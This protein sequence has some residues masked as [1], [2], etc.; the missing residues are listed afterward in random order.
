MR[1][2]PSTGSSF[3]PYISGPAPLGSCR[4]RSA[5]RRR[6]D[7]RVCLERGAESR[8][9][10]R[11][12][13]HRHGA[14]RRLH[15]R[16]RSKAHRMARP[17]R[18]SCIRFGVIWW[19]SSGAALRR[20]SVRCAGS[21]SAFRLSRAP[22]RRRRLRQR[23]LRSPLRARERAARRSLCLVQARQLMATR[24]HARSAV[25]ETFTKYPF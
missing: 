21:D 14:R 16:G 24:E 17:W 3:H 9:R 2:R 25:V 23:T 10:R 4:T 19:S 18:G 22:P 13:V 20:F 7:G 1:I 5:V 6:G 15:S 12:C 8:R 11:V